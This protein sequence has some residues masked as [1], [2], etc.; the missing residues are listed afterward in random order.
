MSSG[1]GGGI[2]SASPGPSG[3]NT[4]YTEQKT[5][6]PTDITN[7]FI[8][9]T[10]APTD[11]GE[12]DATVIGGPLQDYGVDFVVIGNKLTWAGLGLDS[13]VDVGDIISVTYPILL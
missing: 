1:W 4:Y 3:D 6:T 8:I 11:P 9:L 10:S 12:T 7:Q 2:T 13:L 5:L